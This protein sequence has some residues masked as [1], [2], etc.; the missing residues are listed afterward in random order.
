MTEKLITYFSFGH[1]TNLKELY[2]G[3]QDLV[4]VPTIQDLCC[5]PPNLEYLSIGLLDSFDLTNLPNGL[6]VLFIDNNIKEFNLLK[7]LYLDMLFV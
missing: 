1:N 2:I 5:L 7:V 4:Q 6:K 3:L